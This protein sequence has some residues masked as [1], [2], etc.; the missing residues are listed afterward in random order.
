MKSMIS[1]GLLLVG[2]ILCASNSYAAEWKHLGADQNNT[3]YFYKPKTYI[4]QKGL[5]KAWTKKE[6]NVNLSAMQRKNVE[7]DDYTGKKS[8]VVYQEFNCSEKKVRSI[9]GKIYERREE[10]D[11]SKTDWVKV[12]PA[13]DDDNLL[14]AL[15]T[16]P[17]AA[18]P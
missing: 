10:S 14:K 5:V 7:A 9:I 11:I 8:I 1:K 2:C 16:S 18:T 6:F 4:V 15:C 13:S 17:P 3:H 12:Q